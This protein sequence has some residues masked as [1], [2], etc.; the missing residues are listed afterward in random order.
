MFQLTHHMKRG[1]LKPLPD[2]PGVQSPDCGETR[3]LEKKIHFRVNYNILFLS[4]EFIDTLSNLQFVFTLPAAPPV[5]EAGRCLSPMVVRRPWDGRGSIST[6]RKLPQVGKR[7]VPDAT[8]ERRHPGSRVCPVGVETPQAG[9]RHPV[10]RP[11]VWFWELR[12]F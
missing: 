6:E 10:P 11:R 5:P 3:R 7:R 4:S 12:A 9:L 2:V 1:T 8:R